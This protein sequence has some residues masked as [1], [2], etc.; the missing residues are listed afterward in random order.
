MGH[1]PQQASGKMHGEVTVGA[2]SGQ[3]SSGYSQIKNMQ[4]SAIQLPNKQ[5]VQRPAF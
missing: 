1:F 4:T 5:F 2:V 3:S